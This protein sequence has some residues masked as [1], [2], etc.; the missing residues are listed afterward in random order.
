MRRP[1][2]NHTGRRRLTQDYPVGFA[3]PGGGGLGLNAIYNAGRNAHAAWK[4]GK[5]I[6]EYLRRGESRAEEEEEV[7][8]AE[9][10]GP[11]APQGYSVPAGIAYT[12]HNSGARLWT[13]SKKQSIMVSH[14]E[15]AANLTSGASSEYTLRTP[16]QLNPTDSN[17]FKWLSGIA[18]SYQNF[19]FH[20]V[21]VE[22]IPACNTAQPG[23]VG[24]A[25]E[26]DPN[27]R[28]YP[29]DPTEFAAY[30]RSREAVPW[31]RDSMSV[32]KSGLTARKTYVV[33]SHKDSSME[34]FCCAGQILV[35]TEGVTPNTLLGKLFVSYVIE[36]DLPTH[37]LTPLGSH[38]FRSALI[39]D[40]TIFPSGS[41]WLDSSHKT[42]R[43]RGVSFKVNSDN[44]QEY[45]IHSTQ[46]GR[47]FIL[48]ATTYQTVYAISHTA[49]PFTMSSGTI[50]PYDSEWY[51]RY[52]LT[53]RGFGTNTVNVP[54]NASLFNPVMTTNIVEVPS[55]GMAIKF[56]FQPSFMWNS[57]SSN[58]YAYS[59]L[60]IFD[61]PDYVVTP[62]IIL[63]PFAHERNPVIEDESKEEEPDSDF[64]EHLQ[65]G[66]PGTKQTTK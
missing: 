57:T 64:G 61:L 40:P 50:L 16:L 20:S 44:Y 36:F 18:H 14:S 41:D 31:K 17:T 35:C 5:R 28:D 10:K 6:R 30:Y 37:T 59:T 27:T 19:R 1:A 8:E 7:H 34:M 11:A 43:S 23:I 42:S 24:L 65:L 60:E 9:A 38:H 26:V 62:S 12:T 58:F 47:R 2:V 15:L 32:P 39:S 53:S 48:R 46:V 55:N 51:S 66:Q 54:G 25:Y 63:L 45:T 56:L 21:K 4:A 33:D 3:A 13:G 29:A 52:A 22:Y 49:D